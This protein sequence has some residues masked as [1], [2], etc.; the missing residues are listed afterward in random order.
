MNG[1]DI[2]NWQSGE[3]PSQYPIKFCI[4]KATEGT[5]F[6]DGDCDIF[7]QDCIKNNILF[8]Y[9]H[10]AGNGDAKKEAKFF[11]NNTLGY[12]GYGIP[13]LDYETW[14]GNDV[15][16]C[17]EFIKE[18]HRISSVY[19]ILYISASRCGIFEGSWIPEKCG[20]WVA[21]YPMN[22]IDFIDSDMPYNIY[23]WS[24]AAIWQF[25]S[26]LWSKFDGDIAYMDS[27][28]WMKYAT[29]GKVD[30]KD[31]VKPTKT[32]TPKLE[33]SYEQIANE[34]IAGKWGNGWNRKNALEGAG[35][36]YELVQKMVDAIYGKKVD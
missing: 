22:Y 13:V 23:P 19:P 2:S 12:A 36:D 14:T 3:K 24:F 11:W 4:C 30:K 25:T 5:N 32:K 34:V 8:G 10:F 6:V 9:Y 7:I 20:L 31:V 1:I 15:K 16:W 29:G 21:G 35:Y 17:E 18:Y 27:N 28:G 33:K 26:N